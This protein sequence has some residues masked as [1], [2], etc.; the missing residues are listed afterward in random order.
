MLV[1]LSGY[2]TGSVV[3]KAH[4]QKPSA[5]RLRPLGLRRVSVVFVYGTALNVEYGTVLGSPGDPVAPESASV[6]GVRVALHWYSVWPSHV[7]SPSSLL[8]GN[9][10]ELYG[11]TFAHAPLDLVRVVQGDCC[12]VDEYVFEGVFAIDEAVSVFYVKPL[13]GSENSLFLPVGKAVR[14]LLS[15]LLVFLS[16]SGAR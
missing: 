11:F 9:E 16:L 12:L 6:R 15:C 14:P 13:N 7:G 4:L 3:G 2:A 10:I 8:A 1:G 5:G